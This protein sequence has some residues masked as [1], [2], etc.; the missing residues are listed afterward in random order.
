VNAPGLPAL[1]RPQ[2]GVNMG[3]R[4]TVHDTFVIDRT[5]AFKRELVFAAWTSAE[6]KSQWFVGPSGWELQRR[7]LDFRVGGRE[8]LIGRRP[9]G[10]LSTFDARYHEILPHE[11]I[12]YVYDMHTDD[13]RISIS[14]VTVEFKGRKE[15]TQL[16]ITEQ[17]VFLD[18][19]DAARRREQG[20]QK[21]IDQLEQALQRQSAATP[22]P[23]TARPT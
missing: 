2:K 21:L 20:T 12:V 13:L 19:L 1:K 15:G 9:D 5:F 18:D 3:T 7:E 16:V 11:R 6:A 22:R 23:D 17:G 10:T 8:R 4:S 14:L